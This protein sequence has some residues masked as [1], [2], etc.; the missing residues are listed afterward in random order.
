MVNMKKHTTLKI[1]IGISIY[2]MIIILSLIIVKKHISEEQDFEEI[3][4]KDD[5]F[6]KVEDFTNPDQ[7]FWFK[8]DLL[9]KKESSVKKLNLEEK[10][11]EKFLN[12]EEKQNLGEYK[13]ELVFIDYENH[14]IT[15]FEEKA[16]DIEITDLEGNAIY[17]KSF[18]ETVMPLYIENNYL[19]LID[20]YLNSPERTYRVNL[21]GGNIELYEIEEEFELEVDEYT[22]VLDS[23]ND[24][25]FEIPSITRI[26]SFTLNEGEDRFA[27]V[28]VDGF[29]WVYLKDPN[30]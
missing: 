24:V 6:F 7:I 3:D 9:V 26:S 28:D 11:L 4:I 16:T 17:S 10:T 12:I 1:L 22:K 13:G 2:L 30:D 15:S 20:N 18:H 14:V 27:F 25:L 21:D 29:L 23:K 8:D 19:F 5:V